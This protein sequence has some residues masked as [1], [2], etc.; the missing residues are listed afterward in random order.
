MQIAT[1]NEK[2]YLGFGL[3][4]IKRITNQ[5]IKEEVTDDV[6]VNLA[7]DLTHKVREIL[8]VR[9]VICCQMKVLLNINL[10]PLASI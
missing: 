6:C 5:Y 2:S 3:D 9:F 4:T 8:Q 10:R 7:E 1:D